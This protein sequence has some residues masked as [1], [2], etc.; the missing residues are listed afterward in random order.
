VGG[1]LGGGGRL[2]GGLLLLGGLEGK[3]NA[4]FKVAR[5]GSRTVVQIII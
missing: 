5:H 3:L 4:N 1:G 2:G